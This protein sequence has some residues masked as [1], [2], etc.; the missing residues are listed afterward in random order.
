[1]DSK[2]TNTSRGMM[3]ISLNSHV[4]GNSLTIKRISI[5]LTVIAILLF[6]LAL[7][8]TKLRLDNLGLIHSLPVSYFVALALLTIASAIIWVS[9]ENHDKLLV[10]QIFLLIFSLW[11]VPYLIG[12]FGNSQPV[13]SDALYDYGNADYITRNGHFDPTVLWKQYWPGAFLLMSSFSQIVPIDVYLLVSI[14]PFFSTLL[15]VLILY[16][17]FKNCIDDDK[18]NLRWVILWVFCCAAWV[19][20]GLLHTQEIANLLAVTLFLL[21]TASLYKQKSMTSSILV[22]I[23]LASLV[24]THLLTFILVL[25]ALVAFAIAKVIRTRQ[26]VPIAA[27]MLGGWLVYQASAFIDKRL[28][29]AINE[30]FKIGLLWNAN[31]ETTM[32]GSS[33]HQAVVQ[34]RILTT[35]LFVIV[36]IIGFLLTS[37]EKNNKR[38]FMIALAISSV[39]VVIGMGGSYNE[40]GLQRL[41]FYLLAPVAYF[42]ALLLRRRIISIAFIAFLIISLPL[43]IISHYGNQQADY[44]SPS[45]VA[46]WE[47]LLSDTDE[48][49]VVGWYEC[50]IVRNLERYQFCSWIN[51]KKDESILFNSSTRYP[52]YV[53]VTSQNQKCFEVYYGD[54]VFIPNI[55]K[56][57][58]SSQEH[59]LVLSSTDTR[60]Y[61][62]E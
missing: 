32:S 43:H 39:L 25:V 22:L 41:F 62:R 50:G 31:V 29:L 13:I 60:I 4:S 24:V 23:V 42:A 3:S 5:L 49:T 26:F 28:P 7:T 52:Q 48:G 56:Q 53:Y 1:M 61:L 57:L 16:Q 46:S 35:A 55:A 2:S 9:K 36:A 27:V 30:I 14:F 34:F 37:R 45:T 12:G 18:A 33:A 59:Q 38:A 58:E 6:S 20:Y 10:L 44:V 54:P 21:L 47:F 19:N 11:I 40:S 51:V 15:L 17:F 8:Q